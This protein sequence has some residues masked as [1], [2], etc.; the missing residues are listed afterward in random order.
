[1]NNIEING[2]GKFELI[3]ELI[4]EDLSLKKMKEF[5]FEEKSPLFKEIIIDNKDFKFEF[6]FKNFGFEESLTIELLFDIN[7]LILSDNWFGFEL[8]IEGQ[9][10]CKFLVRQ[11][12]QIGFVSSHFLCFERQVK[13]PVRTLLF[14]GGVFF[15]IE[16]EV[17]EAE[18]EEEDVEEIEE[19]GERIEEAED[20]V[21]GEWFVAEEVWI[22]LILDFDIDSLSFKVVSESMKGV[23]KAAKLL[24]NWE[25]SLMFIVNWSLLLSL[26]I[27]ILVSTLSIIERSV[28]DIRFE[29]SCLIKGSVLRKVAS[30]WDSIVRFCLGIDRWS[31]G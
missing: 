27:L 22:G 11:N 12:L 28:G 8:P 14:S 19:W 18:E 6:K 17:E 24:S 31:E 9:I 23:A 7:F 13:Q 3:E 29:G 20:R 26:S 15:F 16:E 5:K 30:A 10:H 21:L 25:R 1:M 4:F 2:G